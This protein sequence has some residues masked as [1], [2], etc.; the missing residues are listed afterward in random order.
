MSRRFSRFKWLQKIWGDS[1]PSEVLSRYNSYVSGQNKVTISRT[2]NSLPQRFV[3]VYI[4]PF[5]PKRIVLYCT[6]SNRSFQEKTT[7][8][9]NKNVLNWI[10]ATRF[11]I[12]PKYR[13]A[14]ARV[15]KKLANTREKTSSISGLKYRD[16]SSANYT[17]P[18][19]RKY[20]YYSRYTTVIKQITETI[21][22]NKYRVSFT[23]E[24]IWEIT[25]S[26]Q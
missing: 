26:S 6:C 13:P 24:K 2:E 9:G 3:P 23:P 25:S 8:F 11:E 7:I 17:F 15:Y 20:N 10:N 18:F 4:A 21:D 5:Q 19:G 14:K 16:D 12:R 1:P 22:Y